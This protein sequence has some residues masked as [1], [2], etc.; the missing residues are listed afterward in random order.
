M[1]DLVTSSDTGFSASDDITS[2]LTPTIV[3]TVPLP[4]GILIDWGD[5]NGARAYA[6]NTGTAVQATLDSAYVTDGA[7]TITVTADPGGATQSITIIVDSTDPA[8]DDDAAGVGEDSGLTASLID[9]HDNDGDSLTAQGDLLATA[10]TDGAGSNGG[11]FSI[12]TDGVVSFDTNGDFETLA[13]NQTIVTSYTFTVQDAAGNEDTSTLSVT[14]TGANDDPVATDT[15]AEITRGK[16]TSNV[17][18]ATDLLWEDVDQDA[19]PSDIVYTVNGTVAFGFLALN[20]TELEVGDTFTQQDI[21]DGNVIFDHNGQG[22]E[23]LDLAMRVESPNFPASDFTWTITALFDRKEQGTDG[24]DTIVAE[25]GESLRANGRKGNDTLVGKDESDAL[26]GG[27]GNDTLIGGGG[28]DQLMGQ[29]GDDNLVGNA[30]NDRIFGQDGDDVVAG[31]EGQ[32][33]IFGGDGEDELNGGRGNDTID[34]GADNDWISGD[35]G[36][37]IID[38]G[39]GDDNAHGGEG[40]DTIRGQAGED[41][42]TG[43]G[44]DD[45]ISGG[46]G[47]DTISGGADDDDIFGNGGDDVINGDSGEDELRGGGG[48][49]TIYGGS[50][51]DLLVGWTGDDVLDGQAGN[52]EI[53]GG[54]GSNDLWG[55]GGED[56][57]IYTRQVGSALAVDT[58]YDFEVGVD[59]IDVSAIRNVASLAGIESRYTVTETDTEVTIDFGFGDQL[60]LIG[61]SFEA[62]S[63]SDF[64]FLGP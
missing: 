12:G 18:T 64:I 32:D 61:V 54:D 49:D 9:I 45:T 34:G 28:R 47:A 13:L 3:F 37:D 41:T 63:D 53:R 17:L 24:D 55:G 50:E 33:L 43:G 26:F 21:L 44:G 42:I 57:F 56:T 8:A 60:I 62:L 14:V 40:R 38:A 11:L 10:V 7:K 23:S 2:D 51:N 46:S 6:P 15:Q 59:R 1:V 29:A 27:D 30:G 52:D 5:G 19:T 31:D 16:S 36:N 4:D 48:D 35:A 20:G 58:I 22:S 25:E 39:S